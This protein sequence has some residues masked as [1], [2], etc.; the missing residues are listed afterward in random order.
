MSTIKV[1]K[2]I[3]VVRL[4]EDTDKRPDNDR[5]VRDCIIVDCGELASGADDGVVV[6]SSDPWSPAL[7][8]SLLTPALLSSSV[9]LLVLPV[10]SSWCDR[11]YTIALL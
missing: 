6:D 9:T 5:P 10:P 7:P 4:I 11:P 1:L 3:D 2:G 8:L